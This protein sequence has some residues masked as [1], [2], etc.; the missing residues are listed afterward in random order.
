M[1]FETVISHANFYLYKFI[2]KFLTNLLT[3]N[4]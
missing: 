2:K 1:N 4:S 3:I